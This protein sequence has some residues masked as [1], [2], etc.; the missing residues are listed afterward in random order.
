MDG[1]EASWSALTDVCSAL[2]VPHISHQ[3]VV[4]IQLTLP[5]WVWPSEAAHAAPAIVWEVLL[6]ERTELA[7]RAK[8]IGWEHGID[9][10]IDVHYVGGV[11]RDVARW[12]RSGASIIDI[13]T[14][15]PLWARM[16]RM[17]TRVG[18]SC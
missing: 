9:L 2:E 8:L 11:E 14:R 3:L 18:Y 6:A 17:F 1:G 12:H 4:L 16:L 13:R 15:S 7:D 10:Q 5:W